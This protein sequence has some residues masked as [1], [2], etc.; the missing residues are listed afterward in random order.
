MAHTSPFGAMEAVVHLSWRFVS[1]VS[2]PCCHAQARQPR[3]HSIHHSVLGA[4]TPLIF[5][6]I[7]SSEYRA[8]GF[9]AG[10]WWTR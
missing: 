10:R 8:E 4:E 3:L 2:E 9:E 7:D 1:D 6:N 5:L